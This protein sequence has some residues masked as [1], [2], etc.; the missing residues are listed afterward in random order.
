M[1]PTHPQP[2]GLFLFDK[3]KG[4]TSHDAVE[5]L[6]RKLSIQKIG[7]TGTLD[8]MATGLLIF[9]VGSATSGQS[10]MQGLVKIYGGTI[11]F[12]SETDTWD[13]EGKVTAEA[14]APALDEN[15]V[16]EAVK[17]F[18]GKVIQ[19]IP[20]YSAVRLNG[21]HMYKLARRNVAMP[22]V[23][24]EVEIRWLSWAVRPPALDFEI[25]CSGGTYVRSVAH[26]MG[27]ALGSKA[28]LSV[29]RRLSI[30]SWSVKGSVTAE[31]LVAMPRE[32]ALARLSP[33]PKGA[34][35]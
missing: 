21:R 7:H 24:R 6:R 10:E 34:H 4:I 15:S 2:S 28:H 25:E 5:L 29:L 12:G 3:P 13:A 22:E 33:A 27:R 14:P 1:I 17:L 20:P 26:E 35:A 30:G 8:P 9:M 23:R 31:E 11:M 32:A 18:N 16:A 19:Q